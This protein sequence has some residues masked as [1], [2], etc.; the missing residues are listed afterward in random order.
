MNPGMVKMRVA[1]ISFK[2]LPIYAIQ[3]ANALSKL[4]ELHFFLVDVVT[5]RYADF[6]APDVILHPIRTLR[7]RN[8]LGLFVTLDVISKI[9]EY[10]CDIGHLVLS[11]PWFNVAVPF[12]RSFPLV[13]TVHDVRY[14][15]GDRRS[16]VVPQCVT[17]LATKFSSSLIV[18]GA[19]LKAYVCR[20][21]NVDPDLVFNI[22]HMNYSFYR[23][24]EALEIQEQCN[25]ILF[26][27]SIWEYKGLKYLMEAEPFLSAALGQFKITIAGKGEDFTKYKK[28][29]IDPKNYEI[30][31]NFIPDEGVAE[32]FRKASVVVLPYID[33]SQSGVVPLAFAF[34]KPVVVTKV[35]S[36]PEV[37]DHGENGFIVE[38]RDS[39]SIAQAIITILKDPKLKQ[40]MSE[41]AR[42][43]A[44]NE[45]SSSRIAEMHR[46][47]Y[48][49]SVKLFSRRRS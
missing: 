44:Y 45:L 33:A 47:A 5:T 30:I 12:I 7:Y 8:P 39:R 20:E 24:W 16:S 1:L 9:K 36:I 21:F 35:G 23:H 27:G 28:Y 49:E 43:K 14:H 6:I 31:N 13:T 2:G 26:F 34:G 18:H 22:P 11:E 37:V 15:V 38:S 32:L 10:R 29:I 40:K 46:D 41:N 48:V 42:F 3:L 19:G 4:V 17:D 25:N